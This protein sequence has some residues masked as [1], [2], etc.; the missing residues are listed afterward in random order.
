MVYIFHRI[1]HPYFKERLEIRLNDRYQQYLKYA[2]AKLS[3]DESIDKCE[4]GRI[5]KRY[6]NIKERFVKI[7]KARNDGLTLKEVGKILNLSR[8]RIRQLENRALKKISH[9]YFYKPILD[10]LLLEEYKKIENNIISNKYGD[11]IGIVYKILKR[12]LNSNAEKLNTLEERI[13]NL[14]ENQIQS[15]KL[16]KKEEL[17]KNLSKPIES[18]DISLRSYNCMRFCNIKYVGDIVQKTEAD[19]LKKKNFGMKSLWEIKEVLAEMGLSLGMKVKEQYT[20]NGVTPDN[21]LQEF[22][23][24]NVD[25]L[26][27]PSN[28][29]NIIKHNSITKIAYLVKIKESDLS[30]LFSYDSK[31]KHKESIEIEGVN[32]IKKVLSKYGLR[33]GMIV[34]GSFI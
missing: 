32:K 17:L 11:E 23:D 28:I 1:E 33:L 31:T 13:N 12:K 10:E 7:L 16:I 30:S 5:D 8:E 9:P 34:N 3:Q 4:N 25:E 14:V 22:L 18:L 27:L 26:E 19:L 15:E 2:L 29:I 20:I 21:L 24:K 6:H